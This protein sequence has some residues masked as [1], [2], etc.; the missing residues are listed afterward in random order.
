MKPKGRR[1]LKQ[2]DLVLRDIK[3]FPNK[4]YKLLDIGANE[5][6]LKGK[7]PKNI[8]YSGLDYNGEQDYVFDLEKGRFPIKDKTF[9]IIVCLETLEHVCHPDKVMEEILRVSKENATFF[10]SMPNEYNF[11]LR[12]Y[13]LFGKKTEVQKPFKIVSEHRHIHTPRVKDIINFFSKYIKITEKT[14]CWQS[15]TSETNN[16]AYMVDYLINI[17]AKIYPS[18][19]TRLVVVKGVKK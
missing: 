7:L 16:L 6:F 3:K 8:M 5:N 17:F 9:D 13:Y 18:V 2:L 1:T 19:F 12:L 4:K 10:L 15:Q 11:V 14:F